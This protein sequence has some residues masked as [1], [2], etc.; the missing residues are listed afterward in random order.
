MVENEPPLM[1]KNAP[2][3]GVKEEIAEAVAKAPLT[4]A[5]VQA[6]PWTVQVEA[7]LNVSAFATVKE[8]VKPP[9]DA[10]ARA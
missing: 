10:S 4:C 2:N 3:A 5:F 9:I 8:V 1:N 7:A 6:V